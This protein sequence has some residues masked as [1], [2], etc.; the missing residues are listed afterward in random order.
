MKIVE[1][2]SHDSYKRPSSNLLV[3]K[4]FRLRQLDIFLTRYFF[5][6]QFILR[7]NFR[8]TYQLSQ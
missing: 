4:T 3:D 7:F 6:K 8:K 5:D 1:S 2:D